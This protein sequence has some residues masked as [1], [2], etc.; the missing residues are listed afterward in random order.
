[1]EETTCSGSFTPAETLAWEAPGL[2]RD[3]PPGL[4]TPPTVGRNL[5]GAG[6][7]GHSGP[8]PQDPAG[9]D[10]G[11]GLRGTPEELGGP[12]GRPRAGRALCECPLV[13]PT[14]PLGK[15]AWPQRPFSGQGPRR[16]PQPEIWVCWCTFFLMFWGR[17]L[18]FPPS[19]SF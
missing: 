3:W 19:S 1:M 10:Q 6:V 13:T 9:P 7:T 16:P 11:P 18:S 12:P 4:R 15:T 2:P 5:G 8:C 14:R 17:T